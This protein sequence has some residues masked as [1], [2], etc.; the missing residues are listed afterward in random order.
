V[1]PKD[2]VVKS[3]VQRTTLLGAD[4]FFR[5]LIAALGVRK[6]DEL[7]ATQSDLHRA[8]HQVI[9]KLQDP[10]VKKKVDVN[11]VNVDYDS[12]YGLSGWFDRALTRAQRDLLI[13]FP[14]PSYDLIKIGIKKDEGE[15]ILSRLGNKDLFL[16]LADLFHREVT[17]SCA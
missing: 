2:D 3:D 4:D 16:K 6:Y 13:S 9:E 17:T 11:L 10:E 8:F 12:L 14:N 5:G 7:N 15:K 1:R